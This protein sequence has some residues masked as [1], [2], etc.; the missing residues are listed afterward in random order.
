ML[1]NKFKIVG[2]MAVQAMISVASA[3]TQV[4]APATV[5]PAI[6]SVTPAV[7]SAPATAA[8]VAATG[9][10]PTTPTSAAPDPVVTTRNCTYA[11]GLLGDA[12]APIRDFCLSQTM[13]VS[14][15]RVHKTIDF[16]MGYYVAMK[17]TAASS[18]LD[19]SCKNAANTIANGV[20]HA[21]HLDYTT[22]HKIRSAVP[23]GSA[24]GCPCSGAS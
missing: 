9:V 22:L 16:A 21:F 3:T 12:N 18:V 19:G 1:K 5:T 10:T 17:C 24:S 20:A 13:D 2:L 14:T 8:P 15:G 23:P 6:A 7:G 11:N 4:I